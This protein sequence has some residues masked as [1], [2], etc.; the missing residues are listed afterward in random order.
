M[1][2]PRLTPAPPPPDGAGE[3]PFPEY[4]GI[5]LSF[6]LLG[7]VLMLFAA[8]R[9]AAWHARQPW[10]NA[11]VVVDDPAS[12]EAPAVGIRRVP[13]EAYPENPL[14]P[15]LTSSPEGKA[16][17]ESSGLDEGERVLAVDLPPEAL[18][19]LLLS[20]RVPRPGA[21]EVLAGDLTQLESFTLDGVTFTVVGQLAR[22]VSVATG[23]YLL[24]WQPLIAPI[25][26]ADVAAHGCLYLDGEAGL[27]QRLQ[28]MDNVADRRALAEQVIGLRSRTMPVFAWLVYAAMVVVAVGGMGL[29]AWWC[30]LRAYSGG[31]FGPLYRA[32]YEQP[33][34]FFFMH[35][36]L[37]GTLFVAMAVGMVNPV[38]HLQMGDLVER[39]FVEGGLSYIGD[40]YASGNIPMAAVA[41]WWNNYAVQT[42]GLTFFTPIALWYAG[43]IPWFPL[44]IPLLPLPLGLLKTAFSF[45]LVG[46]VMAPAYV[47]T[48]S[49][50]SFHAITM[51]LELEAYIIACFV[52]LAWPARILTAFATDGSDRLAA[53]RDALR[54]FVAGLLYTGVLLAVA[55]LYEAATL[56][57]LR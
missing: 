43:V 51:V 29:A 45:A 11:V 33:N 14:V 39:M 31:R 13:I 36:G 44:A 30:R 23:A 40:A 46:A 20:G 19:P 52:I 48:A 22:S 37:Y 54:I 1:P 7:I 21:P 17:L 4:P 42:V 8:G 12:A 15:M 9:E 24:P 38:L 10:A 41:T 2:D 16:L 57:L 34:L 5:Y 50:Y 55:G 18:Q 6:V 3:H 47:G 32:C 28:A 26:N 49:G 27:A 25:F 56:I 35:A 53:C